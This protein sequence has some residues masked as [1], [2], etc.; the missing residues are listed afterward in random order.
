MEGAAK[1]IESLVSAYLPDRPHHLSLSPNTRYPLPPNDKR[2]EEQAI[3]HL[4]YMTFL[5]DV[6]RGILL[7]R[8]YFD[9]RKEEENAPSPPKPSR[10]DPNKPVTKLSLKD[11][12]NRKKEPNTPDLIGYPPP[13]AAAPPIK[14]VA[15]K[16]HDREPTAAPQ[17]KYPEVAKEMDR[18]SEF[19]RGLASLPPKPEIRRPRSPSPD[20]RKRT[21]EPENDRAFKRNKVD[22]LVPTPRL[23]SRSDAPQ[24]G[25][26]QGSQ[27]KTVAR[28]LKPALPITNGRSVSSNASNNG[29]SPGLN[30]S[31]QKSITSNHDTSRKESSH[32]RTTAS[33]IPPLLS[34]LGPLEDRRTE[35]LKAPK[36]S[37]GKKP[38]EKELSQT[39]SAKRPRDDNENSSA[40]KKTRKIPAL[41]S[42]L[43]QDL[44]EELAKARKAYGQKEPSRDSSQKSFTS[45]SPSSA[46]KSLPKPPLNKEDTIH[47]DSKKPETLVV[48]MK[49]PKRLAKTIQRLLALAPKK[50]PE[51]ARKELPDST[52]DATKKDDHSESLEPP[53]TTGSTARKRPRTTTDASEPPSATKRPRTT[54]N[55]QPSTP[56]KNSPTMQRVASSSS[57]V[58]TPGAANSLTPAAPTS[59]DRRQTPVDPDRANR[60]RARHSEFLRLGTRLKHDR[61]NI[62]K[63]KKGTKNQPNISSRD[64]H[65]VMAAAIQSSLAY[66]LSFKAMDDARD[67]ERKQ[68]DP[69]QWRTLIPVF[70]IYT[71]DCKTSSLLTALMYRLYGICL[72]AYN[73]ALLTLGADNAANAREL[74]QNSKDQD[75]TWK[76]AESARKA[77]GVYDGSPGSEDG[78]LVAK[79]IDRLGPWTSPE[80]AVPISLEILRKVIRIDG[81][82]NPARLLL[83]VSESMTNGVK[84]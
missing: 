67:G 16:Q 14:L 39:K 55:M 77:L 54:E 56:S 5:H 75:S 64:R 37:P 66:M 32:P 2:L 3:P 8:A 43:P 7:T 74:F 11:Y 78:G 70:R 26:R 60:L 76:L 50:K 62:M 73:R 9:I 21:A 29:V 48:K 51:F 18:Q 81:K 41:L 10:A 79:L 57:Q 33:S 82:F 12:K 71:H 28:E 30:G 46:K 13:K 15:N 68:R 36:A 83:E 6:D 24:K 52:K 59:S 19:K 63:P 27:E 45:D 34:P 61:D 23:L 44:M 84:N 47:V 69:H 1:K 38:P 20:R 49:Y 53:T 65:V 22:G 35:S 17:K 40:P 25:D 58:G 72:I 31:S 42:P 80:D 4:Q